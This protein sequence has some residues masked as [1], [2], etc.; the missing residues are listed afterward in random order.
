MPIGRPSG[1]QASGT[2]IA[3]TPVALHNVAAGT[4][5]TD[6][7]NVNQLQEMADNAVEIAN[8]YTDQRFAAFDF[9]LGSAR[10]ESRAGTSAALAAAGMP[11]ASD[12]GQN[13]IVAGWGVYRGRAAAA[14]GLSHRASNGKSVFKLGVTYDSSAHVGA[15]GGLGIEF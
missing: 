7:V 4:A 10:K 1:V 12:A 6:G 13:M 9:D 11:Q 15:N 2:D 3:G 14:L 5:G 8:Q